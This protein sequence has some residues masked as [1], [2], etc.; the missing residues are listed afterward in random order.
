MMA[1]D[2]PALIPFRSHLQ[3]TKLPYPRATDVVDGNNDFRETRKRYVNS[4]PNL[5]ARANTNRVTQQG[6]RKRKIQNWAV[7]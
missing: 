7:L 5:I 2:A 6:E 3:V 1:T 4:P